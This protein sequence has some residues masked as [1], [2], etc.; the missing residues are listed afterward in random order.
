MSPRLCCAAGR[1]FCFRNDTVSAPH[2]TDRT[3]KNGAPLFPAAPARNHLSW[4]SEVWSAA[5]PGESHSYLHGVMHKMTTVSDSSNYRQPRASG[6]P[7]REWETFSYST[8]IPGVA[9][10]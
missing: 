7:H 3:E 5:L 1:R 6:K 8:P 9:H 10:S 2:T 4:I